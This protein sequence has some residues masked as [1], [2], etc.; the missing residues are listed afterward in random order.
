MIGDF[1]KNQLKFSPT[2]NPAVASSQLKA[3]EA[4]L[5]LYAAIF[6]EQLEPL[7][8]NIK[9]DLPVGAGL[10][11]SASFAVALAAGMLIST[12]RVSAKLDQNGDT[13]QVSQ[14]CIKRV[15]HRNLKC[16]LKFC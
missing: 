5:G 8:L 3:V 12:G 14:L 2:E 10:G 15:G 9:T 13:D 4:F 6:D 1:L 11:S 16:N 7:L